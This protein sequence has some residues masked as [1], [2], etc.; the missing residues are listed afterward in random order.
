[1][2]DLHKVSKQNWLGP[3]LYYHNI[4]QKVGIIDARS[5]YK[6]EEEKLHKLLPNVVTLYWHSRWALPMAGENRYLV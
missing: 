3:C 4:L 6:Q 5:H 2:A 1:M